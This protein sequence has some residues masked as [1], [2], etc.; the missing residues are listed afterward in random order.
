MRSP[1]VEAQCSVQLAFPVVLKN[2]AMV[3]KLTHVIN[4]SQIFLCK[5][6]K[7]I[8]SVCTAR[9]KRSILLDFSVNFWRQKLCKCSVSNMDRCFFNFDCNLN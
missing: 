6:I 7:L 2:T 8:S 5:C 1:M 4:F 9:W 3:C